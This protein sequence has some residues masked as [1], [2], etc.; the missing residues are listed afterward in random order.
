MKPHGTDRARAGKAV[1]R[2][3]KAESR[4]P[5]GMGAADER[6]QG[7]VRGDCE[8]GIDLRL[9]E[10]VRAE[11]CS[12]FSHVVQSCGRIVHEFYGTIY[13]NKENGKLESNKRMWLYEKIHISIL[14]NR[15]S[16]TYSKE[17]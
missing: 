4:K 14:G 17:V 15:V 5:N 10:E 16:V 9:S 2:D 7:T 11:N 12:D 8:S 3:R 6:L 13:A 1:R